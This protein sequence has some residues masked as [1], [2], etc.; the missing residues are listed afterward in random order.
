MRKPGFYFEIFSVSLAAILLEIA[1]TRIFSFKVY[2]L[3]TYLIIGVGLSGL[4]AGGVLV[5]IWRR[6]R[7][8]EPVRLVPT[9]CMAGSASAACGY[10]VVAPTPINVEL[11]AS[12]PAEMAKLALLCLVLALPFIAAGIVIT[13]ILGSRPEKAGRLYGADLLGAALGCAAAVP[14]L[15]DI[16]PPATIMLA[17]LVFA[18]ASLRTAARSRALL[19]AGLVLCVGPLPA[20]LDPGLLPDPVVDRAKR[21]EDFRRAGLVE[22]SRWHPVFRVDVA[23]HPLAKERGTTYIIH[24][25]G[26]PGSGLR[27]FDGDVRKLSYL[28]RDPRALPFSVLKKGSR[29]LIIGS[30]GGLE[31]LV[32]LFFQA[33]HITAVE[34]NP[35]TV[36]LL[37]DRYADL[38][39]RLADN[40][41]VTLINGDGRW[42]LQ[43][44][45]DTY[46]LIWFV[47]PD[48]YAAMNA[49]SSGAFVLSES[50][51][52]TVE[53]L[54]ESLE[55]LSEN[56]VICTEFGEIDYENRPNRTTRYL[57]TARQAFSEM[58]IGNF[59]RRV[60]TA[61]SPGFPPFE[62]SI[63][64]LGKSPFDSERIMD[65]GDALRRIK[66][67]QPSYVPGRTLSANPPHLAI[68]LR[69]SRLPELY[70][71]YP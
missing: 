41:R 27:A 21:F 57:T 32:S 16:G 46:D 17:A 13:S 34:L 70:A 62:E 11:L 31:I 35:V 42:F 23:K 66:G 39:G 69:E 50:Y 18:G 67:G 12:G 49:S 68:T 58:G 5:T 8:V 63:I 45:N 37:T 30:A 15:T 28:K 29:V 25:D 56:G 59:D 47:A 10:L 52:Y 9:V 40:P 4:G 55:H 54:V 6:L 53:T 26:Q 43:Q 14:L 20:L 61:N 33:A 64:L 44:S 1:Y 65:F 36:S 60:L 22:F 3:F 51:L 24:H 19:L 2:Y 71:S 38:T 7:E 48:S